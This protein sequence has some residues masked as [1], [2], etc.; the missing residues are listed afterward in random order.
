MFDSNQA[1]N[2]IKL[3]K[4]GEKQFQ[5]SSTLQI[6]LKKN[7][8]WNRFF[9][10]LNLNSEYNVSDWCHLQY[11]FFVAECVYIVRIRQN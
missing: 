1:H 2:N 6:Q 7:L 3:N 10:Q 8:K 11:V 4:S 5:K 9:S